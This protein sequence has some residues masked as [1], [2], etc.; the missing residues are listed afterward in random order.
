M[1]QKGDR[2]TQFDQRA[3]KYEIMKRIHEKGKE[4][5]RKLGKQQFNRCCHCGTAQL[6]RQGVKLVY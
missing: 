3:V 5:I 2:L 6:V 1:T 4:E